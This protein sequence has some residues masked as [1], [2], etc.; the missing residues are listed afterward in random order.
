M[1]IVWI[2][3][4]MVLGVCS[5]MVVEVSVVLVIVVVAIVVVVVML[6]AKRREFGKGVKVGAFSAI[7]RRDKVEDRVV[8]DLFEERLDA[9]SLRH[10]A[11]VGYEHD[12]ALL[13]PVEK[14][15]E[16]VPVLQV[17]L[18]V[19]QRVGRALVHV[20]LDGL[21]EAVALLEGG[22]M[23][24]FHTVPVEQERF[25]ERLSLLDTLFHMPLG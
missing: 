9:G 24:R 4:H 25:V 10:L 6:R 12:P 13:L 15:G 11:L 21:E 8:A 17:A 5:A 20:G 23:E 7:Q 22:Q 1:R 14:V 18:R 2:E 3:V 16:R 19:V